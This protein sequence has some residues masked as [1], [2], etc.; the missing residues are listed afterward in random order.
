[1]ALNWTREEV[2]LALDLYVRSGAAG[3]GPVPTQ[4]SDAVQ[5]LSALL[6]RF[7]AYPK[8]EQGA[9][10]RS[11]DAVHL[12]L[13]N[14]RSVQTVG[15]DGMPAHSRMDEAVW[16]EF[17]G[18]WP[19]LAVAADALR[20]ELGKGLIREPSNIPVMEQ[21]EVEDQHSETYLVT[22]AQRTRTA[23]RAEQK[24]VLTY[25]AH[26]Q[27][28]GLTVKRGRY[29]P[30]GEATSIASDIWVPER[31]LLVEAKVSDA[32]DAIRQA[33]GQLYDYRRFHDNPF[34]AVLLPYK[35][36]RDRLDLL[37]SAGIES[38]WQ[39]KAGFSA[40]KRIFT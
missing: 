29:R 40:T 25:T 4:A 34:L 5:A 18:A 26:L 7:S 3:G 14:L 1:V 16:A 36:G 15:K 8:E 24:L 33:I 20:S 13:A 38:V 6:K 39:T 19:L 2:V 31:Q 21:V 27:H 17:D 28:K 32:R 9:K 37:S 10:Y 11:P 30:A 22:T 35:P 12:K 23:S